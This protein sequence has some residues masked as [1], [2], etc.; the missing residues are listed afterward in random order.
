MGIPYSASREGL[1]EPCKGGNFFA[2]GFPLSNE[3][4]ICA[5]LSRLAYCKFE[6]D[7]DAS[8]RVS[9]TLQRVG[10]SFTP[11]SNQGTQAFLAEDAKNKRAFLVFRG[12]ES[13]DPTDIFT[14]VKIHFRAWEP[15]GRVHAGFVDALE[16]VWPAIAEKLVPRKDWRM[17]FTGHSLGAALATLAASRRIPEAL[18]TFGSPLVGDADFAS[19]FSQ[20]NIRR[21][22]DCCD[23]V[24]RLPPE[25]LKYRHVAKPHYI[26]RAGEILHDPAEAVIRDDEWAA[27]AEYLRY[28]FVAGNL[29]SRDLADHAPINY[30]SAFFGRIP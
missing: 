29:A 18:V 21:Y 28:V 22:V 20:T 4:A 10:L 24:C 6:A 16:L 1:F 9:D 5:E 25:I 30:V 17:L 27:R 26:N 3:D 13:R 7:G 14:D 12:T 2:D 23:I 19:L 8:K 15:R 11:F